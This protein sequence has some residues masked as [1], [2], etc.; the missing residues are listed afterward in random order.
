MEEINESGGS[1][2]HFANVRLFARSIHHVNSFPQALLIGTSAGFDS[3]INDGDVFVFFQN[4]VH[5]A[6]GE[7][8][9]INCEILIVDHIIDVAPYGIERNSILLVIRQHILKICDIFVTP[10][11][12]MEA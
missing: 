8:R 4:L 1:W 7:A 3:C 6:E 12:L 9:L 2:P 5:S 11:A 10:S